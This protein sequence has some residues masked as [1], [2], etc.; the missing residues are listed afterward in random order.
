MGKSEKLL[1]GAAALLYLGPL[2]AGLSGIGWVAVPVFIALFALW[3]VVMRPVQW[4]RDLARWTR[5]TVVA[6]AAQVAVN[7]LIVI[8]LFG[9]GRGIGGV[10]GFL[11]NIPPIVPVALSF[12]SIPLSRLLVDPV[13]LAETNQ[14]LDDASR[15]I[16]DPTYVP[17][18]P[19]RDE[20]V[21]VLLSLPADSDPVLTAD[22]VDAAMKGP[23]ANERLAELCAVLDPIVPKN[24]AL[25]EAVILWATDPARHEAEGLHSAQEVAFDIAAADPELL[26]LFAHRGTALIAQH[27]AL[28]TAFPSAVE[29]SMA[30]DPSQPAPLQAGLQKLADAL[31]RAALADGADEVTG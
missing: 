1:M 31:E 14:F 25:R 23:Q 20:M 18:V 16:N 24:R 3:L 12:L 17:A 8:L 30:V 22:A 11:P 27:A 5:A 2:L 9:V 7:V 4:P 26:H 10:A 13:K 21:E 29:V 28:W 15:Q 6:A 19:H